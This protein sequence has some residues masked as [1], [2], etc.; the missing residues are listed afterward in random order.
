VEVQLNVFLASEL[1]KFDW[2]ALHPG[3]LKHK[4]KLSIQQKGRSLGGPDSVSYK[5]HL[6]SAEEYGSSGPRACIW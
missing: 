3:R 5:V 2:P 1:N 6:K 4:E